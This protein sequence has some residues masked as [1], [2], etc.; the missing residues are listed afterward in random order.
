M[1]FLRN[2][3]Q[4]VLPPVLTPILSAQHNVYPTV[5]VQPLLPSHMREDVFQ[6]IVVLRGRRRVRTII[7]LLIY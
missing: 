4:L 7:V 3:V 5:S 1:K 2:A 6:K